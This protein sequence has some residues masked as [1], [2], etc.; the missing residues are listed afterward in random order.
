MNRWLGYRLCL[1]LPLLLS[2]CA[3]T[4]PIPEDQFYRLAVAESPKHLAAPVIPGT[5]KVEPIETFGIYRERPLLYTRSDDPAQLRQYH[6]H[7]WI[8]MP[9]RLI[10]DQLVGYLRS[11]GVASIVA[12]AQIGVPGEVRIHLEL[13]NFERVLHPSGGVSVKVRLDAVITDR[14]DHPL[15]I[16]SYLRDSPVEEGSMT[17]SVAAFDRALGGIYGQLLNDLLAL[18][19][20]GPKRNP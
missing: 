7:Y 14:A 1:L 3:T 12:G 11:S 15:K 4:E 20:D 6:Y 13:K 9:A 19:P 2:A 16:A 17:G 5:L 8:D 18:W 10:R